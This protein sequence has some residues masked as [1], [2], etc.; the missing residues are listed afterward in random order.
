MRFRP[1]EDSKSAGLGKGA[2]AVRQSEDSGP[3]FNR[4]SPEAGWHHPDGLQP[5]AGYAAS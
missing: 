2:R 3:R 5:D 1:L 4:F